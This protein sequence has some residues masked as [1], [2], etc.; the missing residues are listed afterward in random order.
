MNDIFAFS[1]NPYNLRNNYTFY[2]T[3]VHTVTHGTET[4][5]FRGPQTWELVPNGIKISKTL[6]EF[7]RKIKEWKP[8]G[9][10]C[11]LCKTYFPN[12][13]YV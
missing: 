3:N 2:A 7:K 4:I 8:V 11:R 1:N 13:G 10:K 6:N 5:S 12:L 9:C